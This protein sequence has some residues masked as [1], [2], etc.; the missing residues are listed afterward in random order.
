MAKVFCDE[1]T[2]VHCNS[3]QTPTHAEDT[4]IAHSCQVHRK[5]KETGLHLQYRN[6]MSWVGGGAI[7]HTH[8]LLVVEMHALELAVRKS[9]LKL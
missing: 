3:H 6:P 9:T 7:C 2:E 8:I 5:R 4:A 1:A